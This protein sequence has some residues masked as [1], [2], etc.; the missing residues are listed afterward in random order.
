V[1]SHPSSMPVRP[2]AAPRPAN[3]VRSACL[4]GA[5]AVTIIGLTA[6]CGA[7]FT[8]ASLS[9]QPNA[10]AG[11]V[12]PIKVNNVWVVVDPA[13][14]NAEVIGSVA[15][16]GDSQDQLTGVQASGRAA[17]AQAPTSTG[18]APGAPIGGGAVP[19]G[20]RQAVSFGLPGDP[21]LEII[22]A[23]FK[24]GDLSP[25]TFTFANA[26]S[27]TVNAQVESN[28]GPFAEYLP[29]AGN[30][31]T[32][33][34][35]TFASALALASAGSTGTPGTTT[36]PIAGKTTTPSRSTASASATP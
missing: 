33:V 6:G 4:A 2:P 36:T 21:S 32:P 26:G 29:S 11:A 8:A 18:I 34:L 28:T 20:S 9:V 13:T 25:V 5:A 16:E 30:T 17:T 31:P 24:P 14:G 22:G 23:T 19:V 3:R 10:A 35:S 1:S 27:V 15:N 12:G 7:G